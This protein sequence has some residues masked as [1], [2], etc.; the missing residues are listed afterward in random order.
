MSAAIKNNMILIPPQP[1]T[2]SILDSSTVDEDDYPEW[3][4]ASFDAGDRV[5]VAT[6]TPDIHRNYES[7]ADGN[8]TEPVADQAP[9]VGTGTG[10][11][12]LD[13]GPTNTW[14]MFDKEN[15]TQTTNAE[16]ITFTV[17][18]GEIISSASF[19]GIEAHTVQVI[20]TDPVAGEV[21]NETRDLLSTLGITDFYTWQ[22]APLEFKQLALFPN[23]PPFRNAS[24]QGII[25]KT[26]SNAK[27]GVF[28]MGRSREVGASLHGTSFGIKS[29]STI[30]EDQFG[31]LQIVRRGFSN[32]PEF[33][34]IMDTD[35]L[36]SVMALLTS[37]T[38]QPIV[39]IGEPSIEASVVYG[40][41][42]RFRI[43]T[44]NTQTTRATLR[45]LGFVQ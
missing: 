17:T 3:A 43:I 42:D 1:V 4:A 11:N 36:D 40:I 28:A 39:L 45:M 16:T 26:E 13:I 35:R 8:T 31:N 7:L 15:N 38:D 10:L 33:E 21:Y 9:P 19:L 5:M 32:R 2:E 27:C 6:S 34:I 23:L 22:F 14:A 29:S 24:L 25:T 41:Y 20:M 37:T 30:Q 18:P 44:Q 12:W